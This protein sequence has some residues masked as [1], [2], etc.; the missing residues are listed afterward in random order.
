MKLSCLPPSLLRRNSLRCQRL[1]S[2][3][4]LFFL[5]GALVQMGHAQ[6]QT[7]PPATG[8]FL[9]TL[10]SLLGMASLVA[11]IVGL[12]APNTFRSLFKEKTSRKRVGWTFTAAFFGCCFL[13]GATMYR[14][15]VAPQQVTSTQA[16]P[17]ESRAGNTQTGTQSAVRLAENRAKAAEARAVKAE[18]A[19]ALANTAAKTAARKQTARKV[20]QTAPVPEEDD[21]PAQV[22]RF[23]ADTAPVREELPSNITETN[24]PGVGKRQIGVVDKVEYAVL[25]VET[26]S[27]IGSTQADGMFYILRVVASNTDKKTHT[28]VTSFMKLLDEQDR[29]FNASAQG[30]TALMMSGDREAKFVSMPVQPGVLTRFSLVYDAP[31][32]AQGLKL[33]IP[34]GMFSFSKSA[35][36]KVPT[37]DE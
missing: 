11:L 8:G 3:L 31:S 2:S 27:S 29:Q 15:E 18:K 26:A 20:I 19:A 5:T 32:D 17:S 10:F 21:S 28:V 1:L 23:A 13:S 35:V 4:P 14:P 12:I 33:K 34:A 37:P 30:N 24:I 36:I 22:D 16:A 6:A 25:S 7:P 9:S